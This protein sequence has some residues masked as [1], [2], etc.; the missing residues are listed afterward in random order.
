MED[1]TWLRLEDEIPER[2]DSRVKWSLGH[3]EASLDE[4]RLQHRREM[5]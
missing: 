5:M 1:S 4:V 2:I 3:Y